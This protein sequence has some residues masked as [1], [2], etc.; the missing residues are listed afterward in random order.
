MYVCMYVYIYIYIYIYI[1]LSIYLYAR[2]RQTHARPLPYRASMANLG[3]SSS[4]YLPN[5]C[6]LRPASLR[7]RIQKGG[8]C[9]SSHA[10]GGAHPS[11]VVAHVARAQGMRAARAVE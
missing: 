3:L 6:T 9:G 11:G 7:S 1:Y 10:Q 5:G 8:G 4:I 2:V